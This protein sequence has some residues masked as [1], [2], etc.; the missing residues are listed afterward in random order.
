MN[1]PLA[2]LNLV[3]ALILGACSSLQDRKPQGVIDS[4]PRAV[5]IWFGHWELTQNPMFWDRYRGDTLTSW[6]KI[7]QHWPLL[8]A[9]EKKMGVWRGRVYSKS[10]ELSFAVFLTE[11]ND[12]ETL[13]RFHRDGADLSF[14]A[15]LF[16]FVR[17]LNLDPAHLD[18]I[19]QA[20]IESINTQKVRPSG[21]PFHPHSRERLIIG[22]DPSTLVASKDFN[23]FTLLTDK[24]RNDFIRQQSY[25]QPLRVSRDGVVLDGNHRLY[26]A[27]RDDIAVDVIIDSR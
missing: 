15:G 9:W 1:R 6:A 12:F 8:Q 16:E 23:T 19:H 20:S 3:V 14:G 26:E 17:K 4:C 21:G 10:D 7:P 22:V 25:R 27:L 24:R 11:I 5:R 18:W 2:L 13:R